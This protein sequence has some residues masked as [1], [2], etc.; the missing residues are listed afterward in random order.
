MSRAQKLLAITGVDG[1][2]GRHLA[3]SAVAQGWRVIGMASAAS[4]GTELERVLDDYLAADLRFAWPLTARVD[5]VIHL[6]G[7]AAVGPSF[8]QPQRYIEHNS[9]MVTTMGEALLASGART[10]IVGVSTGAVYSPSDGPAAE[11]TPIV[12]G[13]PYVV[14]KLLL[15]HQL[16]YY[17]RRGLDVV[18]VRPFNHIG[19]GQARGFLLPDL[20]QQLIGLPVGQPLHAG[21]LTT[22]RDYTDV[23][24]VAAAYLLLAG[25]EEHS[26]FV[27][28]VASGQALTGMQM[29]E[30]ACSALGRPVPEIERDQARVRATDA[31]RV[32]GD[33]G[34]LRR[35]FGWSPSVPVESSVRDF[36]E[37]VL[38]QTP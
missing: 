8:E 4:P 17:A 5:A 36:V 9:A 22:A 24:D 1:F 30:L 26:G 35:E 16:A 3:A 6:A 34:L 14:S 33:A 15:E 19:P 38:R 10:R 28:N 13:S 12:E 18:V 11:G 2:V 32:V 29:L 27:Y 25:A 7:L 31:R 23:R 37:V 21:D 20:V